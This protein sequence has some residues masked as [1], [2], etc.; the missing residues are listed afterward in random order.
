MTQ[1]ATADTQ[2]GNYTYWIDNDIQNAKTAQTATGNLSNEIDIAGYAPGLHTLNIRMKAKDCSYKYYSYKFYIAPSEKPDTT[3]EAGAS[4]IGYKYGFNE[5]VTNVKLDN[6]KEITFTNTLFDIP[7]PTEF[8]KVEDGKF[9]IDKASST[10]KMSRESELNFSM[11]F[12]GSNRQWS[13]ILHKDTV[14][15][16]NINRQ[17]VE[18][19]PYSS[20][21]LDKIGRGDFHA[22]KFTIDKANTYYLVSSKA[23]RIALYNEDGTEMQRFSET[24]TQQGKATYFNTGTYYAVVYN[25]GSNTSLRLSDKQ[26]A[27]PTPVINYKDEMLSISCTDAD[28]KVYYTLDGT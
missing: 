7:A 14:I 19:K 23:S 21:S 3:P 17:A 5:S 16:D 28:A 1:A 20:I 13:N 22:V 12:Q 27:M 4:L 9:S 15:S 2:Q 8:A 25:L 11:Q 24:D 26:N 10:V 6:L 18:L